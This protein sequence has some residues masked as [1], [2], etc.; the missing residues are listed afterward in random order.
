MRK[1]LHTIYTPEKHPE[2]YP[3]NILSTISKQIRK[4]LFIFRSVFL[5]GERT[6]ELL[7][8]EKGKGTR[9]KGPDTILSEAFQDRFNIIIKNG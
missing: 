5:Y 2:Y 6:K 8:E 1:P 7:N 4:E 3:V 9:T